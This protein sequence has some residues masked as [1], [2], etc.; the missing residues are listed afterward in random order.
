MRINPDQMEPFAIWIKPVMEGTTADQVDAGQII[1]S[2][3]RIGLWRTSRQEE[4]LLLRENRRTVFEHHECLV[5]VAY[6]PATDNNPYDNPE[7]LLARYFFWWPDG[8]EFE[9]MN[10]FVNELNALGSTR[11][12]M[13]C[14]PFHL[15]PIPKPI[16]VVRMRDW[17]TPLTDPR[18]RNEP[19]TV[20][21]RKLP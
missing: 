17:Y 8:L 9:Q 4:A 14:G 1:C 5:A 19:F 3:G 11:W 21:I 7:L 2:E 18:R 16:A 13:R 6:N 20:H 15:D 12:I 10:D